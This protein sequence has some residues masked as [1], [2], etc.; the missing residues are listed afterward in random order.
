M[1]IKQNNIQLRNLF[2]EGR[3]YRNR[4]Y[5][6]RLYTT[7]QITISISG[8]CFKTSSCYVFFSNYIFYKQ[9]HVKHAGV[10]TI[11][12]PSYILFFRIR[13]DNRD[14][15]VPQENTITAG[16]ST[17]SV[18]N[19]TVESSIQ[20]YHRGNLMLSGPIYINELDK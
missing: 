9:K 12:N 2:F 15:G 14:T 6:I 20:H 8:F 4:H 18:C 19:R 1:L 7:G 5:G 17:R 11:F 3:F 13:G 10:E 16:S